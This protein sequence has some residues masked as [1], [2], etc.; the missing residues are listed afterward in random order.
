ATLVL[1]KVA[2]FFALFLFMASL[3]QHPRY[4]ALATL[5]YQ[6]AAVGVIVYDIT[7]PDSFHK[8]QYWVRS[9]YGF[10][11]IAIDLSLMEVYSE[12][13]QHEQM[14]SGVRTHAIR[15]AHENIYRILKVADVI[16]DI[17]DLSREKSKQ[18][19][20]VILVLYAFHE[21]HENIYR[22]LKVAD[23]ILDRFNL[24]HEATLVLEKVA[25]FFALFMVSL[26]RHPRYVALATLYY[27]G[28]AVGVIVYDITNP[29]LFQKA[30][31]WVR[32]AYG[33]IAIAM[34]LFLMEAYSE[35]V[36]PEQ[37]TSGEDKTLK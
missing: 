1:E 29:D 27:Q 24:S 19:K 35:S 37:M 26:I 8:A 33:Y 3:I 12:S 23:V 32:S 5:Y 20:Y 11:A 34:D 7:N 30:Q 21:A 17:C 28:A 13:V 22:I 9:A 4:A 16:L 25:L 10:I 14:T 6:G 2:L 36:Q 18:V 31:Y 15:R